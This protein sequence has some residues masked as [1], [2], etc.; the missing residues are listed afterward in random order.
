MDAVKRWSVV[1][2]AAVCLLALAGFGWAAAMYLE[3]IP[4]PPWVAHPPAWIPLAA[5]LTVAILTA[6]VIWSR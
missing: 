4:C 2:M 5:F 1:G 6:I 3:V